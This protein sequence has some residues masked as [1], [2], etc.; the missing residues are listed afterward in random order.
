MTEKERLELAHWVIK[1]AQQAGVQELSVSI[2]KSRNVEIE[3]RDKK[4]E[5]L[6]ESTSNSLSLTLYI[7]HRYSAH[8]TN[9]LRKDLL[10]SF[11]LNTIAMTRYLTPDQFRA[12][13]DPHLYENRPDLD[14]QLFDPDYEQLD[15]NQRIKIAA[16]IERIARSSSDLILST[17]ASFSDGLY[18]SSTVK[19][20]GFEGSRISTVFS[21]GAEVT[22]KDDDDKRP[23]DWF[24]ATTRYYAD[25]PAP[26]VLAR[27]AVER[28]LRKLGMKKVTSRK[29]IMIVENRSVPRIISALLGPLSGRALQQKQSFLDGMLNQQLTAPCLTLIDDPF[30]PKGLGSRHFD[31]EGISAR[32]M[33]VLEKGVLSTYYIDT[34]YGKKLKMEP[35]FGSW[36]NISLVP[37]EKNLEAMIAGTDDGILVTSFLGGNSNSTTGDFSFGIQGMLIEDGKLVQ[38]V[39]EMNISGNLKNLFQSLVE[40]GNDIYPYSSYRCPSLKFEGVDFSGI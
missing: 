13:P 20:N 11:I 16:E 14:L 19:S 21:S 3:F 35:S 2:S 30:I 22:I 36:S 40:I 6:Q 7:D 15:S 10:E 33:P 8:S 26:E 29:A 4:M 17:T 9:D 38:P 34:Y 24:Y 23:E 5:K 32:I 1:K 25:L 31:G 27:Q 28:T 12:L 37:G 39:N 18:E